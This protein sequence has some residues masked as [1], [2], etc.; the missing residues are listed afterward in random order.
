MNVN[1][2]LAFS[3]NLI[4]VSFTAGLAYITMIVVR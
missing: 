4:V 3:S 1:R 2:G